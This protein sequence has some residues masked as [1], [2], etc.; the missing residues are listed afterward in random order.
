MIATSAQVSRQPSASNSRTSHDRQQ[1]EQITF[2]SNPEF[3]TDSGQEMEPPADGL[4]RQEQKASSAGGFE[5][6]L[7]DATL[8]QGL[9]T[10]RLLTFAG[11]Q[12]LFRR[13][14]LLRYRASVLQESLHPTRPSQRKRQQMLRL[15][16]EADEVRGE[17]AAA[18]LRLVASIAGRL[19]RSAEEFDEYV[20]E[21]NAVLLNAIDRFDFARGFRFSTYATHAVQRRLYRFTSQR[22]KRSSRES[23]ADDPRF[24]EL[25]TRDE[26]E[27]AFTTEEL[28]EA[29]TRIIRQFDETL[30]EREE[31]IVRG[32]FGLDGTGEGK[33]LRTLASQF[34]LSKERIRQLLQRA[35]GKLT[36][37]AEPL[38]SDLAL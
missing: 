27:E 23:V 36:R 25:A 10:S 14:N 20:A 26:D 13:M 33:T 8:L 6:V 3:E 21:G 28:Y 4:Y 29:A 18:N 2:V 16:A 19:S 5:A 38:T 15:L 34:G 11:E 12:Y 31:A 17:I 24:P 9:Q 35:I 37:E 7:V 1:V 32:R 30:D 22:A